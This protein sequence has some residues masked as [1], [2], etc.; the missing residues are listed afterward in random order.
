[1]KY[2]SGQTVKLGDKVSLGQDS[3]GVVVCVI[4][5]DE[6]SEGYPESQWS[7]L[8]K[9][10]MINFPL[11]GLIHYEEIEPDIQLIRRSGP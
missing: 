1:M 7:Y 8:Q 11:H 9:G 2:A 4:D 6:Y 3:G 5:R 10:V